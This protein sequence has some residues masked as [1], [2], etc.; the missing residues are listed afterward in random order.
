MSKQPNILLITTDTQRWDTL[1]C[2]GAQGR[3]APFAI[4]PNLD[5]LAARGVVFTN[6]YSCSAICAPARVG[7]LTGRYPTRSG[8]ML[9]RSASTQMIALAP[10]I[11]ATSA[12][13]RSQ[14]APTPACP[15]PSMMMA[16]FS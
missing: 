2:M 11:L 4:S 8:V 5:A 16:S 6:F 15:E 10:R 13:E 12:L 14:T 7:L 9:S 3:A 1:R